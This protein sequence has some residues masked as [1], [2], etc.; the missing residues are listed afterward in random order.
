M[1]SDEPCRICGKLLSED[2]LN[3]AVYAGYSQG[4]KSR[5]AHG[6]CWRANL[7]KDEWAYPTDE[8]G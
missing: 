6:E 5:A 2:D 4:D 7:P 1:Y 8:K 3:D